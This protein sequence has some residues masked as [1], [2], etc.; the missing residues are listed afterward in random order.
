[1]IISRH[2]SNQNQILNYKERQRAG[3]K[4]GTDKN[5]ISGSRAE[6]KTRIG[7][8]R[9]AARSKVSLLQSY[10]FKGGYLLPSASCLLNR[11]T[12]RSTN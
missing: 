3:G 6:F 7:L 5:F 10:P 2:L 12:V 11:Y 9:L 4:K 1:M 8:S